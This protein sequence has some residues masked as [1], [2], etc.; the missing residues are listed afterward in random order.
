MP[1]LLKIGEIETA[2]WYWHFHRYSRAAKWDALEIAY[3]HKDRIGKLGASDDHDRFLPV[4]PH[5]VSE[6]EGREV[7]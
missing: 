1:K 4:A 2:G 5:G 3:I 6:I 7:R